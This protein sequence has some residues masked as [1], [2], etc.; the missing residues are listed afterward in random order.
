MMLR[1][2]GS[3]GLC[4]LL[5][6]PLAAQDVT[7]Q[8]IAFDADTAAITQSARADLTRLGPLAAR[9]DGCGAVCLAPTF[10]APGIAT[11]AE[12]EVIRFLGQAV[13]TEGGL[14]I[15]AR[16]RTDRDGGAIAGSTNIPVA[17]LAPDNPYRIDILMA[18]GAQRTANALNF[19]NVPPVMIYDGGPADGQAAALVDA[20]LAAGYP[21]DRISYY[22]GGMLVWV[23]LGLS[24][25]E[26]AS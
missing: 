4:A 8:T 23:A 5:A 12:P 24:V 14:L 2:Y 16:Q 1:K 9:P 15:D 13:A 26:T 22:R 3:V 10:V 25:V 20:L 19:D 18:L 11:V 17:V 6:T 21:A 7:T